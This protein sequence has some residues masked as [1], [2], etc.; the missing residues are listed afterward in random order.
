[1]AK[2]RAQGAKPVI[3]RSVRLLER[4]SHRDMMTALA[5][6][7]GQLRTAHDGIA[8]SVVLSRGE[9]P[10]WAEHFYVVCPAVVADKAR[11]HF[12]QWFSEVTADAALF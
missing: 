8:R 12:E 11:P 6:M 2:A 5:A 1:M 4:G 7:P 9:A 10:P 3:A